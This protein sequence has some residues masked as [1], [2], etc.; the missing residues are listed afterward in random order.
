M[1]RFGKFALIEAFPK[2]LLEKKQQQQKSNLLRIAQYIQNVQALN[3]AGKRTVKNHS[4][5]KSR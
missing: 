1:A 3:G 4:C 2:N 5:N